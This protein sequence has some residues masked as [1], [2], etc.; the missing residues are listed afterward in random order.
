MRYSGS[1]AKF[2]KYLVP[3]LMEH[4]NK[5]TVFVDAF[6]GGANVISAIPI[7]R[8]IGVD[9]NKYVIALWQHLL[10]VGM[11][12]I[13]YDIT[14]QDYNNIKFDYI[15]GGYSYPDWLIGYVGAC[16]SY[17]SAWFNGYAHFNSKRGE[18][19][20]HEAYN[21]LKKHLERFIHPE[22]TKF[23]NAPY[24]NF[25]FLSTLDYIIYCDPPY[26]NKKRYESDF[27]NAEFWDWAR[28]M[29]KMPNVHLYVSEYEAPFDFECIWSKDK[30]DGMG[31]TLEGGKQ[32][33]KTE[34]LFIYNKD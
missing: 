9:T 2:V 15:N 22:T 28:M 26:A 13:P 33:V 27:N 4:A 7:E 8:K 30:P 24:T 1:K 19:H 21:G 20:I 17:G 34:N 10:S 18:N 12:G 29:S 23:F 16:C 25:P 14:E 11:D 3:I 32:K 5:N 31:T 6:C